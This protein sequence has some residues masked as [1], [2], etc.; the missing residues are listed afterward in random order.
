[1]KVAALLL[2]ALAA[3]CRTRKDVERM[4]SKALLAGGIRAE[5][6]SIDRVYPLLYEVALEGPARST[7]S[8][9]CASS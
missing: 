5:T 9:R 1:M 8:G 3:R 4:Q 2:L 6:G 7:R